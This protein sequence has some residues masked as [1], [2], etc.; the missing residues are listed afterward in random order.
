MGIDKSERTNSSQIFLRHNDFTRQLHL[1][2]AQ[3]RKACV[4]NFLKTY[5]NSNKFQ[6]IPAGG[7][8][9]VLSY[10]YWYKSTEQTLFCLLVLL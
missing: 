4:A 5:V 1:A 2:K 9:E 10:K 6:A 3:R 8:Q 7:R